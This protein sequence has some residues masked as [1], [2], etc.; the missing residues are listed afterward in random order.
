MEENKTWSFT[1]ALLLL[2]VGGV[3][4]ERRRKPGRQ[5]FFHERE[6][7]K[8]C[9]MPN[10]LRVAITRSSFPHSVPGFV[11]L[12]KFGVDSLR[13]GVFGREWSRP[14]SK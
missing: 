2:G 1:N 11:S 9:A 10:S 14:I 4:Q 13:A 12:D 5:G 7:Q 6:V 8:W 3:E